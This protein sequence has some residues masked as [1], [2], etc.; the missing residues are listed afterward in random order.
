MAQ[1]IHWLAEHVKKETKQELSEQQLR[2]LLRTLVYKGVIPR[3][4]TS[5]WEFQGAVDHRAKAVVAYLKGGGAVPLSSS[6]PAAE[7]TVVDTNETPAHTSPDPTPDAPAV[8][9]H[10]TDP[11]VA[12]TTGGHKRAPRKTAG[13]TTA[14]RRKNA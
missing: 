12:E 11:E 13:K 14:A 2:D 8:V 9:E 4:K 3:R 5:Q 10:K 7:P 1:D 6:T